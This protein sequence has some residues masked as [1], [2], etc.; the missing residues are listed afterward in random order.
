MNEI[1]QLDNKTKSLLKIKEYDSERTTTFQNSIKITLISFR[2]QMKSKENKNIIPVSSGNDRTESVNSPTNVSIVEKLLKL[3]LQ[4]YYGDYAQLINFRNTFKMS[5]IDNYLLLKVE[6]FNYK[7][8]YLDG[9]VLNAKGGSEISES[10]YNTALKIL[11]NR[12]GTKDIIINH[13]I[14]KLLKVLNLVTFRN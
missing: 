9:S 11:E 12:Y 6:T 2:A 1:L 4:K 13:H 8:S 3:N 5:L 10:S 7:L 14:N